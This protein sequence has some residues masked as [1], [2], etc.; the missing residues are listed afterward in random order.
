MVTA[1]RTDTTLQNSQFRFWW[2]VCFADTSEQILRNFNAFQVG[3]C[4]TTSGV[5]DAL[6]CFAGNGT[7]VLFTSLQ[8]TNGGTFS[9]GGR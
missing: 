3:N 4:S 6:E 7:W 5:C 2:H 1:A 8:S 9:S